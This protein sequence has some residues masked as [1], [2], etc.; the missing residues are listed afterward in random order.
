M[1]ATAILK[2]W[3]VGLFDVSSTYLYSPFEEHVL[4]KLPVIF[5]PELYGK[6]LC[7]KKALYGMQQAGRSWWKFL[8]G[9][10]ERLNFVATKVDQSLYIFCSVMAVIAI[11]I[12]INDIVITSNLPDTILYF[13]AALC[14]ELNIKWSNKV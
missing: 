6:V 1:L 9:I 8:S 10:L 13:N 11:W 5:L 12:H 14:S 7:L 4:V 2:E 3:P